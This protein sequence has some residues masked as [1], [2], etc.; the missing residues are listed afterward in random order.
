[1]R[2]RAGGR[3]RSARHGGGRRPHTRAATGAPAP[4]KGA[5]RCAHGAG[6]CAR[7]CA[8]WRHGPGRKRVPQTASPAWGRPTTSRQRGGERRPAGLSAWS[9]PRHGWAQ[10]PAAAGHAS[11]SRR[12]GGGAWPWA[13]A[14]APRWCWRC[15]A[16]AL[17]G[18]AGRRPPAW[19][20][21]PKTT[22]VQ[23][24]EAM[25]SR[26][27]GVA[28]GLS[29]RTRRGGWGQWRRRED[30]SRTTLSALSAP[31]G[32]VPG[33]RGAAPSAGDVPAQRQRGSEP[34]C[35]EQ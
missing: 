21:R 17:V 33:R 3:W 10:A 2:V 1:M 22:A 29:P 26:P 24:E 7:P 4:G 5:P 30:T 20:A 27:A 8:H 9:P 23:R 32:R 14:H 25:P 15:R 6:L 16:A 28:Q 11:E 18:A 12:L 34:W 31:G 19:L 35:C 13:G